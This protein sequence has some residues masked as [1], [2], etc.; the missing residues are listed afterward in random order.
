[1]PNCSTNARAFLFTYLT[2]RPRNSGRRRLVAVYP[3]QPLRYRR[4]TLAPVLDV[5]PTAQ[6]LV[7]AWP[8]APLPAPPAPAAPAGGR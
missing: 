6:T 4:P 7:P 1:M 3:P 2:I 5:P 8:P